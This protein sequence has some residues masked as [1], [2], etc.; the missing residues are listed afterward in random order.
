MQQAKAV[1]KDVRGRTRRLKDVRRRHR[2][3]ESSRKLQFRQDAGMLLRGR[4]R[5]CDVQAVA[6]YKAE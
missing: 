2:T 4:P 5:N 6:T 3:R 1:D